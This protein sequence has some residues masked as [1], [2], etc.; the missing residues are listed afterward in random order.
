MIYKSRTLHYLLP[1][2]YCL[3]H[4]ML[5]CNSFF[6][7]TFNP[8]FFYSVIV[9]VPNSFSPNTLSDSSSSASSSSS[10]LWAM[11]PTFKF[12]HFIAC[13]ISHIPLTVL[14]SRLQCSST[15][16]NSASGLSCCSCSCSLSCYRCSSSTEPA[17]RSSVWC[18][19][20]SGFGC[21]I[22]TTNY[23]VLTT[24][25]HRHDVT[26][27]DLVAGRWK[28]KIESY[29]DVFVERQKHRSDESRRPE[30]SSRSS[31]LLGFEGSFRKLE[32]D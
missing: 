15:T 28:S 21:E 27:R 24:D 12:A 5:L 6:S 26:L 10:S 18:W 19:N 20:R 2:Y 4:Y 16:G 1:L 22:V 7:V 30:Q 32:I 3:L 8:L 25:I 23:K 13:S 29:Q 17:R 11:P 31:E 9:D 14:L